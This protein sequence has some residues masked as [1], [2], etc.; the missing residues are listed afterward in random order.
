MI[1]IPPS[2]K[3]GTDN[4]RLFMALR[5]GQPKSHHELYALHM[6]VHSRKSNLVHDHGCVIDT[7]RDGKT[8]WYQLRSVGAVQ[9][10]QA[11]IAD[12]AIRRAGPP[13]PHSTSGGSTQVE[14]GLSSE[15]G[16]GPSPTRDPSQGPA[17]KQLSVFEAAA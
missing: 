17:P 1:S 13:E 16:L 5:S 12:G 11:T 9:E 8:T 6:I 10:G 15:P 14:P 4:Y 3:E 7:W 2:L